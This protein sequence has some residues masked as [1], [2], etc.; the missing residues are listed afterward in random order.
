MESN[1]TKALVN[2]SGQHSGRTSPLTDTQ[3]MAFIEYLHTLPKA[4][5][6]RSE[7]ARLLMSYIQ[8]YHQ[9]PLSVVYVGNRL[10]YL[11]RLESG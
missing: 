4:H 5:F 1:Q 8:H 10:A 11:A 3:R 6:T 2:Q 9:L 7:L